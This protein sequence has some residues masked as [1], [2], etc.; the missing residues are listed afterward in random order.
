MIREI[1]HELDRQISSQRDFDFLYGPD[2][3]KAAYAY[4]EGKKTGLILA[5]AIVKEYEREED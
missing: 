4:H 3:D 1:L 2:R 5:H